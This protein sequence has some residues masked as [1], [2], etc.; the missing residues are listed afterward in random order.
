MSIATKEKLGKFKNR[1]RLNVWITDTQETV[2]NQ[3][4]DVTGRTKTDIIGE[5]LSI[6]F[7]EMRKNGVLE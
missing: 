4:S 3:I 6:Y 1:V 7:T 5:A 2:I